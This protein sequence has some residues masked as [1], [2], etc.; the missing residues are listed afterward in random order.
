MS[1]QI[2]ELTPKGV[3]EARRLI[4]E[5]R[6]N[7]QLLNDSSITDELLFSN[8]SYS[9]EF[10]DAPVVERKN[11]STVREIGEYL[12]PR[13]E[14]IQSR[15]VDRASFW[16]WLGMYWIGGTTR[17]ENGERKI[18]SPMSETFVADLSDD[19]SRRQFRFHYVR[20]AWLLYVTYGEDAEFLLEKHPS[21]HGTMKNRI[22]QT[23]RY[24][25]SIGIVP[26][27]FRLYTEGHQQ[28]RGFAERR[29]GLYHLQRVLEQLERTHDVYG[30]EPDALLRIL[31]EE[32]RAWDGGN[33]PAKT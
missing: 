7:P 14:Q 21:E 6:R 25:N 32:F 28:K 13:L 30:M 18:T 4:D 5:F 29:G 2:R 27:I 26:L 16:S 8:P 31:P 20:S 10:P 1:H 23:Q 24:F 17:V 9:R 12:Q 11:F 15:I 19:N 3:Q 22:F 33:G